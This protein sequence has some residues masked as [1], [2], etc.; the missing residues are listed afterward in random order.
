MWYAHTRYQTR[1]GNSTF[2]S[3][4]ISTSSPLHGRPRV[5][6]DSDTD[7]VD[8]THHVRGRH[9]THTPHN[10]TSHC[11]DPN[12]RPA[13][14][15]YGFRESERQGTH[16]H[17]STVTVHTHPSSLSSLQ[18]AGERHSLDS[19]ITLGHIGRIVAACAWGIRLGWGIRRRQRRCSSW[20]QS[21]RRGMER[22]PA[23]L[24]P[25]RRVSSRR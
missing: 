21:L 18:R 19:H 17:S 3:R 25:C 6:R 20:W 24:A 1:G 14:S 10:H 15:L 23:A 16:R 12:D 2:R 13:F 8:T 11:S 22:P 9:T 7:T 4:G 5:P